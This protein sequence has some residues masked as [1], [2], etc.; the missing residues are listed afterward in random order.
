MV[1]MAL[2]NLVA[3]LQGKTPPNVVGG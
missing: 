3:A 1:R 2:V